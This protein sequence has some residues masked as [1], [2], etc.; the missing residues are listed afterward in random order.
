MLLKGKVAIITGGSRG[1]GFAIAKV[2]GREG[3]KLALVARSKRDLE[4]AREKLRSENVECHFFCGDVSQESAVGEV[5]VSTIKVYGGVDILVNNAGIYGPIGLV[6]DLDSSEW[7]KAIQVNLFGTFLMT[8]K[9][10]P[11][12]I[13]QRKGK[14]INLSGGG[15]LSAFPRFSS[16]SA[17]KAAVVRF[18]ETVAEEVKSYSIDINAIA[19]GPVNTRLLDQVLEAGEE[20]AGAD[21]YAKALKQKKEG[22]TPPEKGA[23]LALFLAS[24][25]SDGLTGRVMSAVWDKWQDIPKFLD[26]IMSSDI[27]TMRRIVGRDRG[28]SW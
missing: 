3:A 18:T 27:Y 14:I 5:V 24:H 11:F 7:L 4:V 25:H 28:K 26:D 16:Y 15:A 9:V 17:S 23:E 13:K 2:F 8:K 22:G 20:A 1:I 12:M 19:P 21:F 6:T 10:L